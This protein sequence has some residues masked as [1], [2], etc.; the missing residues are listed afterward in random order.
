MDDTDDMKEVASAIRM[1][2]DAL[3]D[4]AKA[5][6]ALGNGN[7]F[8]P[9]GAMEAHGKVTSDA[10]HAIEAAIERHTEETAALRDE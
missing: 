5:L 1:I 8:T 7:A 6:H 10:M 4:I 2:A 3:D 9:M